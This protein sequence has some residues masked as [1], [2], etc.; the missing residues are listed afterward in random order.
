MSRARLIRSSARLSAALFDHA[1][2]THRVL[3]DAYKRIG[4]RQQIRLIQRLVKPGHR[5]ADVGANIGFY[6]ALL[7]HR[8]GAHGRVW[9][10]EPEP[11]NF[12]HLTARVEGLPQVRAVQAAVTDRNGSIDLYRSP[13]LHVDHRTYATDEARARIAVPAVSLDRY[14]AD[15]PPL[16]FVKM[17][18]QGAEYGALLGMAET[19]A[20]APG[21]LILMEL[22]PFAHDRFGAGTRVLLELLSSW[23]LEVRRLDPRGPTALTADTPL[24]ERDDPDAYFDV[25]CGRAETLSG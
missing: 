6:T 16:H 2:P 1:F 11:R 20:R 17:D 12:R 21:I 9:A 5:V 10:F 19:V 13:D 4:E 14:L 23:G 8:V 22:W 24:P 18:I 25:L 7:A 15:E 3:Y